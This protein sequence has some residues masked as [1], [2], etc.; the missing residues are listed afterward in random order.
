MPQRRKSSAEI[1]LNDNTRRL[2]RD[3]LARRVQEEQEQK[4][5]N[6][7]VSAGRPRMPK[8]LSPLEVAH[9]KAA[10][11]VMKQ[12]GTLSKGDGEALE[13]WARTKARYSRSSK[14]LAEEGDIITETRF[15]KSGTEYTVRVPNPHLKIVEQCERALQAMASKLGL[16]PLDRSKVR[17][18]RDSSPTEKKSKK[19]SPDQ[20]VPGSIGEYM[21]KNGMLDEN[22]KPKKKPQETV[23]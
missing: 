21:Y 16:N 15:S 9:W 6:P 2:S 3:E 5:L 17:A 12:R 19:W 18:T 7:N 13:L 20:I 4:G 1:L 8:D 10:A 11:R 22:G 23:Q 14:A